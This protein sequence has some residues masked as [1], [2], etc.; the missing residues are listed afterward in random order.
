[1]DNFGFAVLYFIF[2]VVFV[3][4]NLEALRIPDTSDMYDAVMSKF[5]DPPFSLEPLRYID[6]IQTAQDIYDYVQRVFVP[7]LF[8]EKPVNGGS[9]MPFCT[10]KYPCSVGQG[11]C[12]SRAQCGGAGISC[13]DETVP[14]SRVVVNGRQWEAEDLVQ[15]CK[16]SERP[17]DMDRLC[18]R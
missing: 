13:G 17:L 11:D 15:W 2:A 14:L 18:T 5:Q 12:D 3:I 8:S 16:F 1:M 4:A 7:T 10:E 9:E 6:D